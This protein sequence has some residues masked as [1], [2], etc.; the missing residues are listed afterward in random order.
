MPPT[1]QDAPAE[2]MY[3][4]SHVNADGV[5]EVQTWLRSPTPVQ[6]LELTTTDPDLLPGSVES[7]DV[8]VRDLDG[9]VLARRESVGTNPQQ[10][11]AMDVGYQDA[12]GMVR[13]IVTAAGTILNV[14]CL[15]PSEDFDASPRPCGRATGD[16]GW[17]VDLRG[18]D[19]G[20]RLLA[21]IET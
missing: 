14:A 6:A 13:R 20:M 7:L 10:V 9:S 12:G 3:V 2:G 1:P 4:V 19:R 21:Q 8:V 15:R 18:A 16:G 17:A 11:L 5:V